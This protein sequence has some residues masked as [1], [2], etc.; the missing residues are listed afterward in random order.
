MMPSPP[1]RP[2]FPGWIRHLVPATAAGVGSLLAL[3]VAAG[4]FEALLRRAADLEARGEFAAAG[5]LLAAP[6]SGLVLSPEHAA[7]LAFERDRL[8]RIE[9]DY[10]LT[11]DAL[12]TRL[13][14]AV[15]EVTPAEFEAWDAEGRFDARTIEGEKRY[16]V[17]SVSNLF[18]RHPELEARRREPRDRTLL[19]QA[20][21]ENARSIRDA[22]RAGGHPYVL[23]KVFHVSMSV[24]VRPG[25]AAPGEEVA[26]W[27]PVP[28]RFPHQDG[29][30]LATE[31]P[32]LELA[33]EASPVRSVFLRRPA[34]AD[35]A[36]VFRID[37]TFRAHGVWFDLRTPPSA[38]PPAREANDLRPFLAEAPHVTF[39][40]GTRQLAERLGAGL[41]RDVDRARAYYQWIAQNIRYSYAPEYS[42]V[43]DLGEV[44]RVSG[45]GDCGQAA[46]LFITLCR[47]SGI[48]ARWQSGWSIFPGDETI[49]DWCEIHLE[50]WGWVPVDP[51]MGMFAR[52][53]ATGLSAS[54]REEL[55]DFSFGGLS[56]YRIAANADHAQ[57]LAPAK[58]WMRSDPV[59]F[60]RGEV[61]TAAGNLYF[62]R[63][64]YALRWE[65]RPD[66]AATA[67]LPAAADR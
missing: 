35:G 45:R 2:R 23:P 1:A 17:S 6:P 20:Y 29:F 14:R 26:A 22:A 47:S 51:Y 21:W 39:T 27:L 8:R 64:D 36:A 40:P 37:Y 56:Q 31:P 25:S 52:Q 16:F 7:V 13:E 3:S 42:T 44:C 4:E 9:R 12:W 55:G 53:Y 62:D 19:H 15:R 61:E 66:T 38:P 67:R 11:R 5:T 28:R 46:L 59:D 58:R 32:F 49:H 48:P 41:T 57:P 18:F 30:I 60:Q 50:P 10:P 65:E 63:F 24:R 34:D 54:Q 43:R 33:G